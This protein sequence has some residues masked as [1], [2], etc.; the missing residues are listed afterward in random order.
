MGEGDEETERT[1]DLIEQEK[2]L[3]IPGSP[4]VPTSK[5]VFVGV[6]CANISMVLLAFAWWEAGR[7]RASGV[8]SSFIQ[9]GQQHALACFSSR[10]SFSDC[11]TVCPFSY[12]Y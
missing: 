3:S 1:D 2:L 7:E 10:T 12:L 5:G 9:F 4:W 11:W 8:H 6:Q